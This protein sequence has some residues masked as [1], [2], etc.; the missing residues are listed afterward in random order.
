MNQNGFNT[1]KRK[2]LKLK[3]V[4]ISIVEKD[5]FNS[6]DMLSDGTSSDIKVSIINKLQ[7]TRFDL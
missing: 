7:F 4:D 3:I 5:V 2:V 6:F 1:T